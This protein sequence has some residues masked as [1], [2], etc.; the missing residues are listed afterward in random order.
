MPF[1]KLAVVDTYQ[2]PLTVS[3]AIGQLGLQVN[4][5]VVPPLT[6]ITGP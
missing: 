6:E 1:A 5:G 3:S 4:S 2:E